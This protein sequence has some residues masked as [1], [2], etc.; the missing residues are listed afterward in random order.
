MSVLYGVEIGVCWSGLCGGVRG[1]SPSGG[2]AVPLPT[3]SKEFMHI[4]HQEPMDYAL[5]SFFKG[6]TPPPKFPLP[7]FPP[8]PG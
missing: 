7:P 3:P 4:G 8:P 5:Y 6:Q 2:R 1:P